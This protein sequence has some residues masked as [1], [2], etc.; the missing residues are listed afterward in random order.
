MQKRMAF[1]VILAALMLQ[2]PLHGQD[3]MEMDPEAKKI[4]ESIQKQS[5]P[6]NVPRKLLGLMPPG[7]EVTRTNWMVEPS[8]KMMGTLSLE[9]LMN[10][11]RFENTVPYQLNLR[12]SMTVYN[13]KT[14]GGSML[15]GQMLEVLRGDAR[16]SWLAAHPE[17]D[18]NQTKVYPPE[19]TVLPKGFILI[20]KSYSPRHGDGEGMVSERTTYAGF[21]YQEVEAGF[22]TA[23]FQ[24]VPNTKAGIEK[25]LRQIASY[26][27]GLR[28]GDCF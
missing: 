10:G 22:L 14:E 18:R 19:K 25:W 4:M 26:A 11:F 20:Q 7:L 15:A 17:S 5:D 1:S 13:M 9:S 23:E 24:A 8:G 6:A 12:I 27:T 3:G 21:L 28:P 2:G 16:D